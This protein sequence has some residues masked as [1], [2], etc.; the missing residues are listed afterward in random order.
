[1]FN[2]LALRYKYTVLFVCLEVTLGSH[3]SFVQGMGG[4]EEL[5]GLWLDY[6]FGKG[7]VSPTCTTFRSPQLSPNQQLEIKSMEVWAVGPEEEDSDDEV[8]GGCDR[9][10]TAS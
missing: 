7:S 3:L 8:G 6:D 2:V 9:D 5:F 1:M 4:R 10:V